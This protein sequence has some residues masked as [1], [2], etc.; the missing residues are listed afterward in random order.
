MSSVSTAGLVQRSMNLGRSRFVL[1]SGLQSEDYPVGWVQL[2]FLPRTPMHQRVRILGTRMHRC[3]CTCD[4]V[5]DLVRPLSGLLSASTM[6]WVPWHHAAGQ[7]PP[8]CSRYLPLAR[9]LHHPPAARL[10]RLP[11]DRGDGPESASSRIVQQWRRCRDEATTYRVTFTRHLAN[12]TLLKHTR[13][14][15]VMLSN[16]PMGRRNWI[17]VKIK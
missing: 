14:G 6:A 2:V 15:L 16:S 12:V 8:T 7:V 4:A 13:S 11:A 9:L 1:P 5:N 3:R 17:A 10:R